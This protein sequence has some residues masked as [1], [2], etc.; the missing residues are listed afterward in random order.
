MQ[1]TLVNK[2]VL[3]IFLLKSNLKEPQ[4]ILTKVLFPYVT[5]MQKYL[6]EV[7]N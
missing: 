3:S 2:L 1:L 5:N 6:Y 7:D 4:Q